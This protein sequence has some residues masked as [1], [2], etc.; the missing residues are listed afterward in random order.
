MLPYDES[1]FELALMGYNRRQVDRHIDELNRRLEDSAIAFDAA[2]SLQNQLN[3]ARTEINKLRGLARNLPGGVSLGDKITAILE[4]AEQ[5]AAAIRARA[6]EDADALLEAERRE[7]RWV[8][9][10]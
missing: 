6:E 8:P 5:Q 10:S 2:V 7:E 9:V 1:N 4:A 3:E